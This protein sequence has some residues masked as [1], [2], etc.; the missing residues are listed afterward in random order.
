MKF[1]GGM[2]EAIAHRG[3]DHQGLHRDAHCA[4]ASRRLAI[5]DLNS[6]N[7]PVVHQATGMILVFNGEIYNYKALRV[8]LASPGTHLPYP[9]R[10]R[11]PS[12]RLC[13]VGRQLPPT[14]A[15]HVRLRCLEAG[16]PDPVP[17]P[18]PH[19]QETPLLRA[20]C[21]TARWCSPR[22]SNPSCSTPEFGVK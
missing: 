17:G 7:Q 2:A 18:R 3:P 21:P 10:L 12:V 1:S 4:L 16:R 5:I 9:L 8:E 20:H 22:K 11:S 19:G 14:P 13:S 15:R 6:G